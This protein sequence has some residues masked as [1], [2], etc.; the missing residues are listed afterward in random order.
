MEQIY[1]RLIREKQEE[2]LSGY[3]VKSKNT[4]GRALPLEKCKVRTEFERDVGKI[5]YS[6][7]FRRLRHKTQVF[8]NPK[9]DHICTRMEHVLYVNYISNT[10]ARSLNLNP[11]L[12]HAISIGHDI[13]HSPFGHSGEKTLDKCVKNV[14]PSMGFKHELHSL[15]VAE[16]LAI[17]REKP[18]QYG[19]NLTFEVRD[20]IAS[21]CGETYDE[22]EL[23]PLRDKNPKDLWEHAK[24]HAMPATLE[25]CVVRFADKIAYVGR[26]IED[27]ARAGIMEFE[28]I[29]TEIKSE[30]GSTNGQIINTLVTDIVK[31]SIEKDSICL[32]PE[33]GE[34]IKCLL[35]E[36][37]E[38][39]YRS[40][41][42]HS[43]EK[44][45]RNTV[46]SLFNTLYAVCNDEEKLEKSDEKTFKMFYN[47]ILERGYT[48]EDPPV[49]K[50]VDF[51]AGMTDSYAQKCYEELYWF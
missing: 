50:V 30:L 33:K 12:V 21:H 29:P 31:N 7:E 25:G 14:D 24:A 39:I 5:L 47:Y 3:A 46:E 49:Q 36:N 27:A 19:Y 38:K 6:M 48:P 32:S 11:D 18:G 35:K 43:Y 34:A 8:F 45:A 2:S 15:R 16:R 23:V 40:D 20:G 44:M 42:I 4:K 37:V 1:P 9:N 41:K 10:I 28:D 13:G 22:V 26:D 17:R 51:I